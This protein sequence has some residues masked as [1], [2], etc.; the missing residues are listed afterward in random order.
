MS[1]AQAEDPYK[2]RVYSVVVGNIGTVYQGSNIM[3]ASTTFTRYVKASKAGTGRAAGES[4]VL[5]RRGEPWKE[6]R[7][8]HGAD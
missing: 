4:A 7:G 8:A 5:M 6:H 3:A 2:G 1:K